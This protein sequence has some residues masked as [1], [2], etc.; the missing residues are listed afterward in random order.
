MSHAQPWLPDTALHDGRLS[1]LLSE[2]CREWSSAW[3]NTD[4]VDLQLLEDEAHDDETR[5]VTG[6]AVHLLGADSDLRAFA[7][8]LLNWDVIG[9]PPSMSDI[10]FGETIAQKALGE[11]C[12]RIESTLGHDAPSLASAGPVVQPYLR[13]RITFDRLNM[14][15][16]LALSRPDLLARRRAM[17]AA[18]AL[19]D[20]PLTARHVAQAELKVPIEICLARQSLS[21]ADLRHL[22]VGDVILL[23]SDM[24][25]IEAL[26]VNGT[27]CDLPPRSIAI[28]DQGLVLR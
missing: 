5:I 20:R 15:L 9:A 16:S 6:S 17:L 10:V 13:A 7:H 3:L 24:G 4:G 27:A 18:P 23:E 11:L 8:I 14:G 25:R 22:D 21:L 26:H 12:D 28:S 1:A 2:A 19:Q